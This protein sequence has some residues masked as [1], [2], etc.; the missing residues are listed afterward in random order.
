MDL[1]REEAV[2]QLQ[3][4]CGVDAS[5]CGIDSEGN[6]TEPS[7]LHHVT[8]GDKP[9]CLWENDKGNLCDRAGVPASAP[10]VVPLGPGELPTQ[11]QCQALVDAA[12]A[13][14]TGYTAV[15][16]E[17]AL[18]LVVSENLDASA[19]TG[20]CGA[21]S[22]LRFGRNPAKLG[23]P[24]DT[25]VDRAWKRTE[26]I[27]KE[28]MGRWGRP[29]IENIASQLKYTELFAD[30]YRLTYSKSP[31]FDTRRA[32]GR[33]VVADASESIAP[34]N[35]GAGDNT[36]SDLW[37]NGVACYVSGGSNCG[38]PNIG[39]DGCPTQW[40]AGPNSTLLSFDSEP[41]AL[42][43]R[44]A[45]GFGRLRR[46]VATL[47]VLTGRL[48]GMMELARIEHPALLAPGIGGPILLPFKQQ[49]LP[50]NPRQSAESPDWVGY[51]TPNGNKQYE[52]QALCVHIKGG[53]GAAD[54][55]RVFW[56]RPVNFNGFFPN[57]LPATGALSYTN[58][59]N[60]GTLVN[61]FPKLCRF[62]ECN[63]VGVD[64]QFIY[65]HQVHPN[66]L[67][68]TN[69][70][71]LFEAWNTIS[72]GSIQAG[73][74][75][76]F[77][78]SSLTLPAEVRKSSGP[79]TTAITSMWDDPGGNFCAPNYSPEQPLKGAVWR[80]FC[81]ALGDED[82][83]ALGGVNSQATYDSQYMQ[84]GRVPTPGA[85]LASAAQ[86]GSWIG[87]ASGKLGVG[88]EPLFDMRKGL[89]Q[90]TK[91]PFQYPLTQRNI[92]DAVELACHARRAAPLSALPKCDGVTPADLESVSSAEEIAQILECFA[93]RSQRMIQRFVVGGIPKVLIDSFI[94]DEPLSST[95][96]LGGQNLQEMARQH[97]AL[98]RIS[99]S[100]AAIGDSQRQLALHVR[101][102]R[103]L[104][105]KKDALDEAT[106]AL[107]LAAKFSSV[108]QAASGVTA[109]GVLSGAKAV[110][111]A[112][113]F[114][115]AQAQVAGL[116]A[117]NKAN[118]ADIDIQ[119]NGIIGAMLGEVSKARTAA[120]DL[121]LA[122][123]ELNTA[124]ANLLLIRKKAQQ[125][126]SRIQFSDFAGDDKK[127]PQ[128]VNVTM[129]RIYNT[130]LIRYERAVE[131]AKKLAFL[132]RRAIELRYGV[133]MQRMAADMTL[134]EAPNKW[135]N[136]IC[137][138]EGIDYSEIR[139]PNPDIPVTGGKND[140]F[141]APT[142]GDDFAHHYVGD[143]VKKL[144][145]FLNSYP[146]DFPLKD[147]DDTAVISMADDV[148]QVAAS[149]STPGP[150]LLYWSTEVDKRDTIDVDETTNGWLTTGCDQ[151]GLVSGSWNE[152]IAL[153]SE[154]DEISVS[155]PVLP[156]NAVAYRVR[157]VGCDSTPNEIGE[158]TVCPELTSYSAVGAI[159]QRIRGT[160]GGFHQVSFY[161]RADASAVFDAGNAPSV[162]VVRESDEQVVAEEVL[163]SLSTTIWKRFS[164]VFSASS[165]EGYRLE[166]L[167]STLPTQ[168]LNSTGDG[169]AV[170]VAAAQVEQVIQ[171]G[172]GQPFP[173]SLFVRTGVSRDVIDVSCAE[174][175]GR[176]FRKRFER[177]CEYVCSDGIKKKC[178]AMDTGSRPEVCFYEATFAISLEQIESG[179]LIPSG[180]IAIGNFN[181]RHN[182]AGVNAVGTGTTNCDG[183][184]SS[185][186]ANG[187]L[188]YT[189]SHSGNTR[190][191]NY[192]GATLPAKM[193]R[194]FIEHGKMLAA[195]RVLTN[196]LG[197]ADQSL[198]ESYMKGEL[199]GRPLQGLYT[200]RNWDQP[201]LRWDRVDD[202]QLAWKYHYW[203]RFQK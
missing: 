84:F 144:E 159:A 71:D 141:G 3:D 45:W 189:L 83:D 113:H 13:P 41:D 5:A 8:L 60:A 193:D 49:G 109:E 24:T 133:D 175:R 73:K 102:L 153:E 26:Y 165:S 2:A 65:C 37:S 162:R 47:G 138:M 167:P 135:V 114:A 10:C 77:I 168:V 115:A 136:E 161:A 130:K 48:N 58:G 184:P 101:N 82:T 131:R 123:N 190:I 76:G 61:S 104:E 16:V 19:T 103:S 52:D 124:S 197:S 62:N 172:T 155:S 92:Q 68:A 66:L 56:G 195:E 117:Q 163:G 44:W 118:D 146:I 166:I 36:G 81:Q 11:V 55:N 194:A 91:L 14:A 158:A 174:G 30:H 173:P 42:A 179:S 191:R 79:W 4:L 99:G 51:C 86:V 38:S 43:S 160:T 185:C 25:V 164:F 29:T 181:F 178:S 7:P 137:T 18:G 21:F 32:Q 89:Y 201:G 110:S 180:Q 171:D 40:A 187:F 140:P 122:L 72:Y 128:Y 202:L 143:Y 126:V 129:R 111:A 119:R 145:D 182:L 46:A 125:A 27:R 177:K 154:P 199:K 196:P 152:C 80:A 139:T 107:S 132:A 50:C 176:E 105:D 1:R 90:T 151:P 34:C 28:L 85:E 97:S 170:F 112:A 94:R 96:G 183:K 200:L 6:V 33:K 186:Y 75:S 23:H 64:P 108:A 127:D 149:C 156:T 53:G 121:V 87:P 57:A 12:L 157:N 116:L 95:S 142:P 100:Y 98:K 20:A 70:G 188:E 9:V 120:D 147:S 69:P 192:E 39:L 31:V 106:F 59:A 54:A 22:D 93:S 35:P 198:M 67:G 63:A 74:S 88:A 78:G 148:F 15:P 169:P 134:V 203:T 150:N 17:N